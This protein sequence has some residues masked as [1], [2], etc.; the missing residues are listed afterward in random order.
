[1]A[2]ADRVAAG[3]SEISEADLQPLR[4]LGLTDADI[5]DIILAASARCFFS[6]VLEA[7]GTQPDAEYA[8]LDPEL[9]DALTVGRPI[10]GS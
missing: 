6:S 9:R 5:F 3:P 7:S 4:A 2:L 8:S 10:A 1:M